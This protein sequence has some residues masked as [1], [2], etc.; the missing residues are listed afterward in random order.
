MRLGLSVWEPHR[1]FSTFSDRFNKMF[2]ETARALSTHG[3]EDLEKGS[4]AP[5]VDIYETE[6]S[7]KLSADLPGI[8]RDDIQIDIK[9][10]TLTIKGEKKFEDKVSKDN[11]VRVE[12]EYGTFTR[13]FALSENVD[14]ENIKANYK[15]GVLEVTLPKKEEAKPKQIKVTVN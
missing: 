9:D 5:S 4:W 6:D 8:N 15:D 10:N 3:L 2:A 13:S 1:G 12:R 11:Y 14:P 7:Y